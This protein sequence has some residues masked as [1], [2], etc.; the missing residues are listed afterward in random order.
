LPNSS[1]ALLS[2]LTWDTFGN[3]CVT[4]GTNRLFRSACH[5]GLRPLSLD[6]CTNVVDG[7]QS[8]ANPVRR[9]WRAA[10][11][12]IEGLLKSLSRKRRTIESVAR[13]Q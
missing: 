9:Q 10:A 7:D 1:R 2:S 6:Q 5:F 11:E 13:T 8:L 4:H 3:E 12:R